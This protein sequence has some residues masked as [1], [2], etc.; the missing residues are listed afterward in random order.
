MTIE[1]R[2]LGTG[3]DEEVETNAADE[4]AK[5]AA[6]LEAKLNEA[7]VARARAEGEAEALRRVP[8]TTPATPAAPT[9]EQWQAMESESGMTR[10]QIQ[11]NAR[12]MNAMLAP[13][14]EEARAARL[15]AAEAR[16]EAAKAKAAAKSERSL[17]R[18]EEDFYGTHPALAGHK[19]DIADFLADYSE[20][21]RNDPKKLSKLLE[22]ARVYVRGKVRE[23]M[24]TRRRG[25]ND[26]PEARTTRRQVGDERPAGLDD[27]D[28]DN[29][30][31]RLNLD[32]LD[33]DG[34][35]MLITRLH[36]NPGNMGDKFDDERKELEDALKNA[37]RPDGLGVRIDSREEFARGARLASK[38]KT[39]GGSRGER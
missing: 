17:A 12:L 18:I 21:D 29:R 11:S 39:L 4:A 1:E 24:T 10:S 25:G 8:A 28:G 33:N 7:N 30:E 35:K 3:G 32:D 9:E 36:R 15:D 27:D 23:D 31:E 19:G 34:A 14:K 2:E 6:D 38:S 16:A 20:E 22:K 37:Q 5:K 13:L 26:E